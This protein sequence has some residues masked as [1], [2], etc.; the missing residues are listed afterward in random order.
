MFLFIYSELEH[1]MA[2]SPHLLKALELQQQIINYNLEDKLLLKKLVDKLLMVETNKYVVQLC[3]LL[4][5]YE[6]YDPRVF[7]SFFRVNH[8]LS[9][10]K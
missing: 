2:S 10:G 6:V 9:R 8:T 7:M 3:K 4:V 5:E 1:K